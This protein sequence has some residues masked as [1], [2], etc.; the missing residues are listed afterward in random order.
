MVVMRIPMSKLK[1]TKY[2]VTKCKIQAVNFTTNQKVKVKLC[3]PESI[4]KKIVMQ[5]CH[6]YHYSKISY[7][8]ILG[9]YL[10]TSLGIYIF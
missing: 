3:L 4:A 10:P 6:V 1:M 5:E 7:D 8:M 9:R 2:A